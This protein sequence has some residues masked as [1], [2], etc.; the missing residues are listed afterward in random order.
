VPLASRLAQTSASWAPLLPQA[1]VAAAPFQQGAPSTSLPI[2]KPSSRLVWSAL[3]VVQATEGQVLAAWE[4][5]PVAWAV[6]VVSACRVVRGAQGAQPPDPM[7]ASIQ[8]PLVVQV[9]PV[10]PSGEVLAVRADL[11]LLAGVVLAPLPPWATQQVALV[12]DVP[13]LV[14]LIALAVRPVAPLVALVALLALE[15]PALPW[16]TAAA[17]VAPRSRVDLAVAP[18]PSRCQ[19]DYPESSEDP[20]VSCCHEASPL[21]M[22]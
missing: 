7:K 1:A 19:V 17:L 2:V 8:P 21:R 6:Q 5:D 20:L 4:V 18:P 16:G 9:A 11:V 14:V 10:P 12:A 22:P 15:A 13:R 3:V